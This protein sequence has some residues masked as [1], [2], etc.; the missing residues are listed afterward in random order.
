MQKIDYIIVGQ[1]LAGSA[2]SVQLLQR[3]HRILVF[4]TPA[5]NTSSR[6]SAGLFNPITGNQ[7][8][9]TWLAD[10]L[11]PYLHSYY[12]DLESKTGDR[13]YFPKKLYRPFVS[14]LEQNTWMGSAATA[15]SDY[16]HE[17]GSVPLQ[18]EMVSNPF[19]GVMVKFAGYLDTSRYIS[20]VQRLIMAGGIYSH[21]EFDPNGVTI[22]ENSIEYKDFQARGLI[23]CQGEHSRENPYFSWIPVR[24]LKGET[25]TVKATFVDEFLVNRGVYIVPRG[26]QL[27]KVGATYEREP[28]DRTTSDAGRQQLTDKLVKLMKSRFEIIDQDYGVRPASPDRRPMLGTHPA[29]RNVHIFNGLG[30]KGI[31]LAPYFSGQFADYLENKTALVA[32]ADISRYYSLYWKSR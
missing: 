21:E 28:F 10:T 1:G 30:T 23:F 5:R 18:P 4:D 2:M 8:S 29:Y 12:A 22:G 25:I 24:P 6:V 13:F 7:M 11:F 27:W 3:G 31:T 9:L 17:S 26:N 14:M 19:G 15:V 32:E 20:A 16:L